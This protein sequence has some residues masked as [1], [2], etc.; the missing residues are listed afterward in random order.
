MTMN[1]RLCEVINP[2]FP[3]PRQLARTRPATLRARCSVGYRD[4]RLVELAKLVASGEVNPE[5]FEDPANPDDA[6]YKALLELP[7]IGPYAAANAMQL[8]GRF[9]RLALDSES[10]RHGKAV[11]GLTGGERAIMK[12]LAAHYEPFGPHKFRSYWFELWDHYEQKR[13]PAWTWDPHTTGRTFTASKL[14]SRG[15]R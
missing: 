9:S 2:G 13:G 5:W 1:V 8:L 4:V 11:L 14:A 7:G 3:S 12:R 15:E 10:V 6:V